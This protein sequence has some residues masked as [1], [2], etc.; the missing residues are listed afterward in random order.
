MS[1]SHLLCSPSGIPA[2]LIVALIIDGAALIAIIAVAIAIVHNK[3]KK[4]RASSRVIAAPPAPK[5]LDPAT[6][7]APAPVSDP[8]AAAHVAPPAANDLAGVTRTEENAAA[9]KLVYVT[10]NRSFTAKLA[11]AEGSV[12]A[13]YSL[14]KNV[15]LSYEKVKSRVGWSNDTF[16]AG[17][18]VIARFAVRGKTLSLY[19]ALDP[20]V[21]D[22]GKYRFED[23]SGVKRYERTPVRLKIRSDRGAK[24]A[25]ELI[26]TMAEAKDLK[27]T[28]RAAVDY[29]PPYAGTQALA[30]RG[31]V[32]L[33]ATAGEGTAAVKADFRALEREKFK[34]VGA[35]E[36][37]KS[38]TVGQAA[39]AITDETAAKLVE[40][41]GGKTV[42]GG[43]KGIVNVDTLSGTFAAGETVTLAAVK[44]RGL[45]SPRAG[46]LKVLARGMLDKPLI[47]EASDFSPDAVKMIAL[48]G[49]RAVRV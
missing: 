8:A 6:A 42:R 21:V 36:I 28:E 33:L 43:R 37:R 24:R 5:P 19:L 15:L 45:V 30:E 34:R 18:D 13:R 3:R 7:D 4:K 46:R 31:L 49:G 17:R 41:R 9:E 23:V 16:N 10:Y 27:R 25:A 35:V 44:E 47:V 1:L 14:L 2:V 39:A 29:A 22:G 32:K 20:A 38:V 12:K 11:Q 40:H 48:T 26:A